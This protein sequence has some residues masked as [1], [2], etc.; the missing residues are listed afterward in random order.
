MV[1]AV[2]YDV[3]RRKGRT[4]PHL[5]GV[6]FDELH[7]DTDPGP[8]GRVELDLGQIQCGRHD[9]PPDVGAVV[10][11]SPYWNLVPFMSGQSRTKPGAGSV[12]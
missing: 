10:L 1:K 4:G 7:V 5:R 6:L 2:P 11:P 12:T 3:D 8:D 9:P